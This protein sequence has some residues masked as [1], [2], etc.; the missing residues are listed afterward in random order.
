MLQACSSGS[1]SSDREAASTRVTMQ[2]L[3]LPATAPLCNQ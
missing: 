1:I 2:P 3:A